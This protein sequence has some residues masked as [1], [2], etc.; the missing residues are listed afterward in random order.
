MTLD[1]SEGSTPLPNDFSVSKIRRTMNTNEKRAE[2]PAE[3]RSTLIIIVAVGAA[4]VIAGFFYLLLRST[5]MAPGGEP[6]LQGGVR[7]K[8]QT[9]FWIP[10][11]LMKPSVHLVTS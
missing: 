3:S 8:K 9:S 5:R 6:T 4:I 10:L 1:K 11:K 2:A 7:K